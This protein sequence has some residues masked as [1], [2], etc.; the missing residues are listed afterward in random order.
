MNYVQLSSF[1]KKLYQVHKRLFSTQPDTHVLEVANY[2]EAHPQ[3][4]A[5]AL[6]CATAGELRRRKI[7]V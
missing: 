5:A 6:R 7:S 4:K 2:L 1:D 3:F